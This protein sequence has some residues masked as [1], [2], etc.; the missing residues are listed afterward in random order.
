MS[1]SITKVP[2]IGITVFR[3]SKRKDLPPNVAFE[4]TA[5]EVKQITDMAGADALRDPVNESKAAP[6]AAP[7]PAPEPAPAPAPAPASARSAGG[8]AAPAPTPSSDDI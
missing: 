5:D 7:E 6:E 3:D 2:T 4:F 8:R 1:K